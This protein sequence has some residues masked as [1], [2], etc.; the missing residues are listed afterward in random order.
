MN[1]GVNFND[2]VLPSVGNEV[3]KAT[4]ARYNA[5]ELLSM[6]AKISQEIKSELEA[7]CETFGLELVDV[8]I[9]VCYLCPM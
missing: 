7:R 9:T 3:L 6:R 1:L 8:A 5:E 2:R 4:V